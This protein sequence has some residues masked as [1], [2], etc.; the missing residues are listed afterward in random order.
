MPFRAALEGIGYPDIHRWT[1]HDYLDWGMDFIEANEG[2]LPT[3]TSLD[4]LSKQKR[5]PSA[6]QV[7]AVFDGINN[8]KRITH[9]YSATRQQ[10]ESD[11][12]MTRGEEIHRSLQSKEIPIQIFHGVSSGQEIISRYAK[13]KLADNILSKSFE[14]AKIK[15]AAS[16]MVPS[17]LLEELQQYVHDISMA[18]IIELSGNLGLRR[19]I[20]T[21]SKIHM[22]T[23]KVPDAFKEPRRIKLS[24]RN[25]GSL[26]LEADDTDDQRHGQ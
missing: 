6:A 15:I 23:L 26:A 17:E 19:D 13:Y 2:F 22:R 1:I 20:W 10:A 16:D 14:R 11:Y 18:D 24:L 5:G 21:P 3:A 25:L 8:Y 12:L 9:Q 7:G 4:Y